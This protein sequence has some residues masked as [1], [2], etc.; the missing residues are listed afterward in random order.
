[1]SRAVDAKASVT[2]SAEE[3]AERKTD[4]GKLLLTKYK[5]HDCAV[6]LKND[7]LRAASFFHANASRAQAAIGA[8]YI[9]KVKN[10]VKN[11]NACFV[12]IANGELCFLPMKSASAPYLVNRTFDGR[13]LEGDEL[14]V[15]V[16]REAQKTKQASVTAHISISNEYFVIMTGTTKVGYSANI[17]DG[18]KKRINFLFT[19]LAISC[20]GCL[21]Q[22]WGSLLNQ[23][24]S[25]DAQDNAA[26]PL[27]AECRMSL[28][29]TGCIIKSKAAEAADSSVLLKHFFGL[30]AQYAELL[31]TA[32]H[33][34]CFSCVKEAPSPM[35][36]ILAQLAGEEEYQE[37][38]TDSEIVFAQLQKLAQ[39]LWNP[40]PLRLYKDSLLSLSKLYSIESRLDMALDRRVWLKS[41]GYLVI[42]HTEALTVIDV[43]SG[44][45]EAKKSAGET[46]LKINL[47]A[48]EEIV[49]Q[50]RLRNLSGIIV[51]DFINMKT[52]NERKTLLKYLRDLVNTQ[53]KSSIENRYSTE[54]KYSEEKA[55]NEEKRFNEEKQFNE[56]KQFMEK[57]LFQ[58]NIYSVKTTVV[59]MTPLGLVEITR[60]KVNKPLAEQWAD[61][62]RY[63]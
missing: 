39:Q 6:L 44:K 31:H 4:Q 62:T 22:D 27:K 46:Y 40:K 9:G 41:G 13:L 51:V 8:I 23:A 14:L 47:E 38:V 18:D 53:N 34:S 30:T 37:I 36:S 49:L 21:I 32:L 42:E 2:I 45:Y 33:R 43:N 48:A 16:E 29:P 58:E 52:E 11:I 59:D 28:P 50:L 7:R 61:C 60:K 56:Q 26:S 57:R 5:G 19:E 3:R 54:G 35:E 55:S 63:K 17:G 15:Q 10:V 12:E 1:M 24:A 20:G 25:P